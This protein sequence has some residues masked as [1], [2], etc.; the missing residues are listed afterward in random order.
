[1][2]SKP[3]NIVS[4]INQKGGVGKTTTAIH[5]AAALAM[6]GKRILLIDLDSQCNATTG[7]GIRREQIKLTAYE[8]L[9]NGD[10][11]GGAIVKTIL[12]GLYVIPGSLDLAAV[13][14]ELAAA[15]NREHLLA[16]ALRGHK[17]YDFIIIDCPPSLGLLTINSLVASRSVIVPVQCEFFALEGLVNLV[18]TMRMVHRNLNKGLGICGILLT[19][20][21]GRSRLTKEVSQEIRGEFGLRVF[22]T[23]IPRNVKL[24]EAASFG[25][26]IAIYDSKCPGAI[27]Y[28]LLAKEVATR[29]IFAMI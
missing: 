7:I 22:K 20:V 10:N 24:P 28:A 8:V 1:M 27:A 18:N 12:P 3:C 6:N 26:P 23:V 29:P 19:M 21:D 5:L 2:A 16:K 17:D 14:V 25:R 4:V 11:I 13:D 9:V 15:N